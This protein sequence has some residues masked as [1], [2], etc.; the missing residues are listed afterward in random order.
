[1]GKNL[2]YGLNPIFEPLT[3]A[4]CDMKIQIEL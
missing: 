2:F 4:N 1:M 3:L